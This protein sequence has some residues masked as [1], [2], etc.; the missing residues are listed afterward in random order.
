MV[1]YNFKKIRTVPPAND[2]IDI[3]LSKTQR[4]TPTV[5]HS[6]YKIGRI[7][8]FYMRKIKYTQE[9]FCEKL[10]W[11]LEDFPKLDDIHPFYADLCNVLYDRD[12]Y[13]LALGQLNV[14]K[15]LI[16]TISRDYVRLLKYGDTLYRCKQLKRA[17]LGRMCTLVKKHKNS[18]SYLEEVR[19]HLSRLP[20]IDPNTRTL[21]ITGYPN[22][23]KSSFLNKI[24]RADVDV[25]P[26]AFTTKSLF[27]GH[28]DYKYL[29]Y[30]VIDTPGILDK[31]L[32]DRNTIEMQAITA[33]AHLQC[34]VLY[35]FDLSE[36]CGFSLEQQMSLF[37]NISPL[38]S[39]KPLVMVVNKIDIMK[40]E[41]LG[42]EHRTKLQAL[43]AKTGAPIIEMST[44]HDLGITTVKREACE[45]LIT[46]RVQKKL[47]SK[48]LGDIMNRITVV[49]PKSRDGKERPASIPDSVVAA[50]KNKKQGKLKQGG[51]KKTEKD[52]MWENGGP[53]VY[54]ADYKKQ[55]RLD[56]AEKYDIIP[57]IMDGKN[58]S[59]FID[60]DIMR[61]LE[62]LEKE[63]DALL[64][65]IDGT[66]EEEDSD[67]D[68]NEKV[69]VQSVR[70]KK[71]MLR[72]A[73]RAEKG[74][75]RTSI[76]RKH[77]SKRRN[78]QEF[79]GAMERNGYSTGKLSIKRGA[80]KGDARKRHRDDMDVED[81]A[82]G[83]KRR[84]ASKK[85][86]MKELG[87]K[88]KE[89]VKLARKKMKR[90]QRLFIGSGGEADRRIQ[91]KLPKHIY[92]GKSGL[93]K[94]RSR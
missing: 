88:N 5:I 44:H 76:A 36:Q 93:G 35:F 84:T 32:E 8:S 23:G 28:F 70:T 52:I 83:K 16:A 37:E 82:G 22:V 91:E 49:K 34:C 9:N 71:I 54:S 10:D 50:L 56:D 48:K 15:N 94:S 73:S 87:L 12:H 51:T 72:N 14:A 77:S 75:N 60:P 57:E 26:Y 69:L 86:S 21:L 42:E 79:R 46:L 43:S 4:R 24:T 41:E 38:F 13:K 61:K 25:Q 59:D 53:G 33:L 40:L 45:K 6:G 3:T 20:S 67:L 7:R 62:E 30:Q 74:K 11:I 92:Q 80:K 31:P 78:L 39:N 29:R 81:G 64:G 2:F 19:K 18:L 66:I 55:Y 89:H 90:K 63:E 85:T 47:N 27:V 58:I 17:A 1:V 65:Q 68:E